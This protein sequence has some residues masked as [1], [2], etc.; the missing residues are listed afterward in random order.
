MPSVFSSAPI[1]PLSLVLF[2]LL[3]PT[4]N[5]Q[6]FD[7]FGADPTDQRDPFDNTDDA[8]G[9]DDPFGG[10][11]ESDPFGEALTPRGT[12]RDRPKQEVRIPARGGRADR[13]GE[14]RVAKALASETTL[15]FIETPLAD[16][17]DFI[18]EKHDINV[19][20]DERA[21]EEIG[22]GTDTPL[23]FNAKR[24]SLRSALRLMLKEADCETIIRDGAL[25]ITSD[26]EAEEYVVTKVYPLRPLIGKRPLSD[27]DDA[28]D[29]I[30]D[31][32]VTTV[33][34]ESWSEV[35]GAGSIRVLRNSLIVAN[36]P[37]VQEEVDELL[38]SLQQAQ[39]ALA[40]SRDEPPKF[41]S[42]P[43]RKP[44]QLA[45]EK[46][47]GKKVELD[48]I[49]TP[50][51]DVMDYLKHAA[52]VP[53]QIDH[54]ALN[55]VGIGGDTPITRNLK[56]ITLNS[57]LR[58]VLKELD[59][60]YV[61]C[62]EVL[63]ITTPEEAEAE[64]QTRVY[65]A[66]DLMGA[67]Y[68]EDDWLGSEVSDDIYDHHTMI[69]ILQTIV[70][71]DTWE[72]VG[73]P[74]AI[75]SYQG[76]IVVSQTGVVHEEIATL[77][78]GLRQLHADIH[79]DRDHALIQPLRLDEL[80]SPPHADLRK[81]LA[82]ETGM[83]AF[84]ETPLQD[85]VD[86]LAAKHKL[87]IQIDHRALEDVGLG[88]DVSM[89]ATLG[90]ETVGQA[91]TRLLRPLDLKWI[92]RDECII[93]TTP[94]EAESEVLTVIYPVADLV[95]PAGQDGSPDAMGQADY[96]SL[97]DSISEI[98]HPYAWEYVG[99]VGSIEPYP[100]VRSLIISNT[101][102]VHEEVEALLAQLRQAEAQQ[103]EAEAEESTDEPA[104][105]NEEITRD[106]QGQRL[107]L[108]AYRLAKNDR[109]YADELTAV[110]RELVE[111]QSWKDD[112]AYYLRPLAG[113]LVVRHQLET[114]QKIH[115]LLKAL[116][117]YAWPQFYPG[118]SGSA[119]GVD[120]GSGFKE[121]LQG[122]GFFDVPD[123]IRPQ[124]GGGG[125]GGGGFGSGAFGAGASSGSFFSVGRSSYH[126]VVT[127]HEFSLPADDTRPAM[128]LR[129][130]DQ[131]LDDAEDVQTLITEL[132]DPK[133]W[134]AEGVYLRAIGN[135]LIVRHSPRVH[136]KVYRLL[137]EVQS[138]SPP[139]RLSRS[140][141]NIAVCPFAAPK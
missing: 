87:P 80:M 140:N 106:K 62:D 112:D 9:E 64:L 19:I 22:I 74:G 119:F 131:G 7:P 8:A 101:E 48:A 141:S 129:I 102:E 20:L 41:A 10:A 83:L 116:D 21:L 81:A 93:L 137:M 49:E 77:L 127:L 76:S 38:D 126:P 84:T 63:L 73:G 13:R 67:W 118:G 16:I 40:A 46:S 23:T 94:E 58:L 115:K 70:R 104:D 89:T 107:Y 52:D 15:Q 95:F 5:A 53:I 123:H 59:L 17:A 85:V 71:P 12:G 103:R 14:D 43:Q 56:G 105:E 97:V 26:W 18:A 66:A 50:L 11:D 78:A 136:R 100:V 6:E 122:G 111:P 61:M 39:D 34:P 47:L 36:T 44:W 128:P 92:I 68:S 27:D 121:G 91:L 138:L 4:L 33:Q 75:T 30:L 90:G 1:A 108:K 113:S 24:I 69:D 117:A 37:R 130:Y 42:L 114:H 139:V 2:L 65:P 45:I 134:N 3:C 55:D 110:I 109:E 99:G 25:V 124:F 132:I 86:A 96:E 133:G 57:L 32:I 28:G 35:G 135:K 125:L 82:K 29:E 120:D 51:Q 98:V 54:R 31:V 60:T 88:S 72:Y 79:A